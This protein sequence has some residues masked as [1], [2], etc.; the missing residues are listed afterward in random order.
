MIDL[1]PRYLI[2]AHYGLVEPAIE[3]LKIGHHQLRLWVKGITQLNVT[4]G[5]PSRQQILQWLTD[6]DP[7]FQNI[8]QLEEDICTREDYFLDNSLRGMSDYIS[9]LTDSEKER[10]LKD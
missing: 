9:H 5:T 7:N 6:N 10:I 4:Y 2:I 8:N 3:Y 1:Q